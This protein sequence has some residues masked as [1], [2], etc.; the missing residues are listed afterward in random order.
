MV[1]ADSETKE[2][3]PAERNNAD[4]RP[5]TIPEGI[6]FKC[7]SCAGSVRYS[8]EHRRMVCE[9]CD[10]QFNINAF[11]D[12]S[13]SKRESTNPVIETM[14][15][16][17]PSC[18]ASIHTTLTATTGFCSFCGSDVVLEERISSIRRPAK[19][20][21]F[22]LT[23]KECEKM[24]I[25]RIRQ[26]P[27]VPGE[28]K[29]EEAVGHFRPIYIPFWQLSGKGEG[30]CKGEYTTATKNG[31][32]MTYDTYSAEMKGK[33]SVTDIL[34]DA[35]SQFDDEVAEGLQLSTRDAVPFHPAYLSG[36]YAEAPDTES[37]YFTG[38]ARDYATSAMGHALK[39]EKQAVSA[40]ATIPEEFKE[41]A[42]LILLPVWLLASQQG[43]RVIYTAINGNRKDD[44]VIQ[45]ELP[46][47]PKRF[48]VMTFALA[49]IITALILLMRHFILLRPQ[50]T[51]GLSC[52]LAAV[53]WNAAGP[54]LAAVHQREANGDP[55][56]NMLE[57][58]EQM[59][60]I[61]RFLTDDSQKADSRR[62]IIKPKNILYP[63]L[64]VLG[65]I[66]LS[67][68]FS[69]NKLRTI[70]SLISDGSFMPPAL[71]IVS[72]VLLVIILIKC[73]GLG[74]RARIALVIQIV[75]SFILLWNYPGVKIMYY[76]FSLISFLITLLTLI[77][78][79][80]LHNVFVS[81][82][83]PFFESGEEK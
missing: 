59:R 50:I 7:P 61:R 42:E 26:S 23:R 65:I 17:C 66:L 34:Y 4:V 56:R 72:L 15:Y 36:F 40:I 73:R 11:K 81:R 67:I 1:H 60:D 16:R 74:A 83:S 51:A 39:D 62:Y 3:N 37:R 64:A 31:N 45:S 78:A 33:V 53:C 27:L 46:I 58:P 24:Y 80:R 82:P 13:A 69:R 12:P 2:N 25:D 9:R 18:G 55:T 63:G 70:N 77:R 57:V 71:C 28:M 14:E 75:I 43:E 76:V 52:L 6:N 32:I 47:S 38:L 79:F 49:V 48:T 8:I 21:P 35:T 44:R 68:L 22:S 54:F 10:G 41:D 19:I 30:P 29:A 5:F 20:V